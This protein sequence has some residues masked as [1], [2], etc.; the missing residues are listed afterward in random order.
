MTYAQTRRI[1]KTTIVKYERDFKNSG[2]M[3]YGF[4]KNA[5]FFPFYMQNLM[6]NSDDFRSWLV[7]DCVH[8]T[9]VTNREELKRAKSLFLVR[10]M[11]K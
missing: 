3:A 2:V 8:Y 7:N 9:K 1:R 6:R 4:I 10:A 5:N 11:E